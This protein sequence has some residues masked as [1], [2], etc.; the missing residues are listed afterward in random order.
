MQIETRDSAEATEK[1]KIE[2]NLSNIRSADNNVCYFA[3]RNKYRVTVISKYVALVIIKDKLFYFL[4]H[5][6]LLSSLA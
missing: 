6:L 5:Q 4:K 2:V 1:N 3:D